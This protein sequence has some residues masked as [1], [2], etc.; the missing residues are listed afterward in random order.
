MKTFNQSIL[1]GL[2]L[3]IITSLNAAPLS[4]NKNES[5]RTSTVTWEAGNDFADGYFDIFYENKLFYAI[6]SVYTNKLDKLIVNYKKL[7]NC[8]RKKPIETNS[9]VTARRYHVKNSRKRAYAPLYKNGQEVGILNEVSVGGVKNWRFPTLKEIRKSSHATKLQLGLCYRI[10]RDLFSR[11]YKSITGKYI[12]TNAGNV[13]LSAYSD[14]GTKSWG[15]KNYGGDAGWVVLVRE[16]SQIEKTYLKYPSENYKKRIFSYA[17]ALTKEQIKVKRKNLEKSKLL[18]KPNLLIIP[19]K[20][21]LNKGEFETTSAFNK[22]VVNNTVKWKK[23]IAAIKQKNSNLI[24]SNKKEKESAELEYIKRNKHLTS[25]EYQGKIYKQEFEKSLQIILG[26]P[27]FKNIKY[28]A[29]TQMMSGVVFSARLPSFKEKFTIF[30]SLPEARKFKDDLLDFTLI[31]M[32]KMDYKL[33]VVTVDVVTNT[34]K[35]ELDYLDAKKN[36]TI[37]AYNYFVNKYPK[38]SQV[39]KAN[40]AIQG[41]REK[42]RVAKVQRDRELAARQKRRERKRQSYASKK[43][44]GDKL[45]K[46]GTTAIILSI[47]ITAYVERVNGNN[48]QLRIADTEGTSP[49]FNGVTLYKGTLIWDDYSNWYKCGY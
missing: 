13:A 33:N 17:K 28:N 8:Q 15:S 47:T 37:D 35:I 14:D 46:D 20:P 1:T 5:N 43:H 16:P 41:I 7:V 9:F 44:V 31:P 27:Y 21:K 32:V 39:N 19:A 40:R 48:V 3:L 30:V 10:K 24:A 26:K 38:S 36:H 25:K 4:L 22:R 23:E 2:L 42:Q 29:D 34:R 18:K 45:C 12:V 11:D 49:H 6:P